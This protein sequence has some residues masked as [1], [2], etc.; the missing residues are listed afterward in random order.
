MFNAAVT[1]MWLGR[2]MYLD[3]TAVLWK[4]C[5]CKSAL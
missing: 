1:E 3:I 5:T 4:E 2:P